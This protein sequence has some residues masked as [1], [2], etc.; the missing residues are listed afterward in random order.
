MCNLYSI[1]SAAQAIIDLSNALRNLAGSLEYQGKWPEAEAAF[2]K[3]LVDR[4]N[5]GFALYGI[6]QVK[7]KTRDAGATSVAYKQFLSA[8]K[9]AD[10]GLPEM[11]HAQQWMSHHAGSG[12]S[13]SY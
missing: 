5:S 13:G 6:A 11:Q 3:A 2:Q 7:E 12:N 4:P 1:P 8:W 9:T 10:P